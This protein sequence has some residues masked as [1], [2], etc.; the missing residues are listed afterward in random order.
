MS[1]LGCRSNAA[2]K[3]LQSA[4]RIY[5]T[6][7]ATSSKRRVA[8]LNHKVKMEEENRSEEDL[9]AAVDWLEDAGTPSRRATQFTRT[10]AESWRVKTLLAK[11]LETLEEKK[12]GEAKEI[13][14]TEAQMS[15]IMDYHNAL[16]QCLTLL[17]GEV[18]SINKRLTVLIQI[19][20]TVVHPDGRHPQPA[21]TA[22]T[23]AQDSV[24]L[25]KMQDKVDQ[26]VFEMGMDTVTLMGRRG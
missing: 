16:E 21:Q 8:E 25:E 2:N 24:S 15:Q 13:N 14:L 12:N 6:R 1:D 11:A 5:D 26:H 4:R 19:L 17:Q 9:A 23:M 20:R 3:E 7:T 18:E 22:Q 10:R